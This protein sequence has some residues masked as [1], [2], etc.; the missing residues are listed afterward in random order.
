MNTSKINWTNALIAGLVGTLAFDIVGYLFTGTW[1]DITG[2][3]LSLY[4][5]SFIN[6]KIKNHDT[7]IG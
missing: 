3:M 6:L 5:I 7:S 1:W 4:G 2:L